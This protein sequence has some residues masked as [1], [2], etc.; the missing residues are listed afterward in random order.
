MK[1]CCQVHPK[2]PNLVTLLLPTLLLRWLEIKLQFLSDKVSSVYR[3]IPTRCKIPCQDKL[4]RLVK[5]NN[6]GLHYATRQLTAS[7]DMD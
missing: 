4:V 6:F 3:Q 1:I 2:T 7:K 5:S